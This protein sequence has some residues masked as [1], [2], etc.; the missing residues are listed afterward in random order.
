MEMTDP[1][2]SIRAPVPDASHVGAVR[3]IALLVAERA[4]LDETA[5][6][7]VALIVSEAATN[8]AKHAGGGE[9]LLRMLDVATE[10]GGVE[11]LAVDKGPGIRDLPGAQRD[12]FSTAGTAGHG[13]GAL[14]RMAT[15]FD[16]YSRPGNGTVVL[17]RVSAAAAPPRAAAELGVVCL[18]KPGE[19][20]SGDDW[21]IAPQ[22]SGGWLVMVADGLG[23]GPMAAD[24]SRAAVTTLLEPQRSQTALE[25]LNAAHARMRSTRGAAVGILEVGATAGTV[26]YAG[27]GNI[28]GHIIG[29]TGTQ[30]M[31]SHNGI[32]GHEMR[33]TQ[34][35]DY[36]APAGALIVLHSDGLTS[37][38]RLDGYPGLA[39]RHPALIAGVLYR[40][41]TRGRD[42][43]T[44]LAMRLGGE[45]P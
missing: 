38:W 6:G 21:G 14:G 9:V 30:S 29:P 34:A 5:R 33:K 3:R 39:L 32:V 2:R 8:L 22:R 4:G 16:I 7:T 28:A 10:G 19:Q 44:V 26:R 42:D 27:V 43:V 11:M 15:V 36:Q 23:H 13:L 37:H 35:F 45:T 24:A 20:V 41:C 40:D 25:V 18:P 31:V 12:G 17:A 1:R